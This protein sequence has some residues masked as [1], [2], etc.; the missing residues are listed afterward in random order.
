MSR[1]G[2]SRAV[3]TRGQ[4]RKEWE[5]LFL[6]GFGHTHNMEVPR[7]GIKSEPK[8]QPEPP[9]AAPGPLTPCTTAGAQEWLFNG[10]RVSFSLFFCFLFF[11]FLG[12]HTR[13]TDVRMLGG[14]LELQLPAYTTATATPDLSCVCDLHHS[15]RQGRI[16]NPLREARNRT[17]NLVVPNR[18]H[19]RCATTG[20]PGIGSL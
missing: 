10:Y 15:S 13:H 8:L 20:T 14:Q 3:V 9:A 11:C 5:W 19:F 6:F 12:L 17:R 16:L 7:P 4:G 18:I 2:R 1:T